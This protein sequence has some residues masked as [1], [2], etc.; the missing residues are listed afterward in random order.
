MGKIIRDEESFKK[1]R[2]EFELI[3]LL[4]GNVLEFEEIQSRF[5]I[6]EKTFRRDI[7]V[8]KIVV[9]MFFDEDAR[10]IKIKNRLAY[11]LFIPHKPAILF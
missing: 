2:N 3:I 5:E 1:I 8:I 9:T 7:A 11:M 10:I 6:S 4:Y